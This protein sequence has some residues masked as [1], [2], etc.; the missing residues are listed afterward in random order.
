MPVGR[1]HIHRRRTYSR[2]QCAGNLH[3]RHARGA[4]LPFPLSGSPSGRGGDLATT[5]SSPTAAGTA[6]PTGRVPGTAPSTPAS[7]FSRRFLPIVMQADRLMCR[8]H[9]KRD[10]RSSSSI[11]CTVH[12]QPAGLPGVSSPGSRFPFSGISIFSADSSTSGQAAARLIPRSQ[13]LWK[14]SARPAVRTADGSV[15]RRIPAEGGSGLNRPVRA[16]S[17]PCGAYA[18][19]ADPDVSGTGTKASGLAAWPE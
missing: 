14:R 1:R 16:A 11:T 2:L 18:C 9:P 12:I 7:P 5:T 6:G 4:G 13:T 15:I 19:S 10:G 8:K 3:H 17:P